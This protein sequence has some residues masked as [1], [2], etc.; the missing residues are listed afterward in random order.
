MRRNVLITRSGLATASFAAIAMTACSVE[1][2][3]TGGRPA[4]EAT[5]TTAQPQP[6]S[7]TETVARTVSAT[8]TVRGSGTP[9]ST[10]YDLGEKAYRERRYTDAVLSFTEFTNA[11]PDNPWGHYMLGL[12]A[13]KSGDVEKARVELE[14]TVELDPK[15]VK[16]RLN[17]TRVLLDLGDAKG[18]RKHVVAGLAIDST[19]G[20]AHR[21]MGRVQSS[22]RQN[23]EAIVSY[24]LALRYDPD[25]VWSMNNMALI[26]IQQQRFVEAL[27]PLARAVVVDSSVPVFHN[28]LGIVLE[29][30]GQYSLAT[31]SYGKAV[32]ADS[33]YTKA[34]MSLA[35]VEGRKEEAGLVPVDLAQLAAGFDWAFRC[36]AVAVA[37]RDL[38]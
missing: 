28:N 5:P 35:R 38:N 3:D 11:R 21:L 8:E 18:A 29:H 25:D 27:G 16:G 20:E 30:L 22:L 13:W 37:R 19:S 10:E 12:S 1:K 24:R 6:T 31:V 23:E 2:D 15:H 26:L 9:A 7:G 14:R 17:L 32:R 34:L 33:G 36:G 4:V